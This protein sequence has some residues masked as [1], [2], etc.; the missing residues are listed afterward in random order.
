MKA[1]LNNIEFDVTTFE[2]VQRQAN[3]TSRPVESGSVQE[4][5]EIQPNVY[6]IAGFIVG[7][8]AWDKL[9]RLE[10]AKNR[11][12]LVRYIGR[13]FATNVAI[14][15]LDTDH[16]IRN[17]FAFTIVLKQVKI[18]RAT[19]V[20]VPPV[21]PFLIPAIKPLTNRGRQQLLPIAFARQ[22]VMRL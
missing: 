7:P 9:N 2:S 3:I 10:N 21:R 11:K 18:T 19:R 17:G 4:H 13:N 20:R 14:E 12:S 8:N 5:I 1:R 22:R 6:R 16:R 15:R